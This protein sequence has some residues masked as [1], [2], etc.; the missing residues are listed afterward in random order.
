MLWCYSTSQFGE[1]CDRC[2]NYTWSPLSSFTNHKLLTDTIVFGSS[3]QSYNLVNIGSATALRL[4]W[5]NSI[6]SFEPI[7]IPRTKLNGLSRRMIFNFQLETLTTLISRPG[8]NPYSVVDIQSLQQQRVLYSLIFSRLTTTPH[9]LTLS[10]NQS[11]ISVMRVAKVLQATQLGGSITQL[12]RLHNHT[13]NEGGKE[14]HSPLEIARP[15]VWPMLCAPSGLSR[16]LVPFHVVP[17]SCCGLTAC[18]LCSP[19]FPH[20]W[21]AC[22]ALQGVFPS[23]PSLLLLP[24]D[25][26]TA[27]PKHS[28]QSHALLLNQNTP[29]RGSA[30]TSLCLVP[31]FFT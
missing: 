6:I 22:S 17:P 20:Y 23:V 26:L 7:Q 1:K 30:S 27:Q 16:V 3:Q 11:L 25:A 13:E 2:S 24:A 14:V 15:L 12:Y 29:P 19:K 5:G 10:H 21:R 8:S 4:H 9:T 18:L 31:L 28:S